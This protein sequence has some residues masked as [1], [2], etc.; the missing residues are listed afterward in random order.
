V[1]ISVHCYVGVQQQDAT[2][3]NRWVEQDLVQV[4][5]KL[6][7]SASLVDSK[8]RY[9]KRRNENTTNTVNVPTQSTAP[10]RL[11]CSLHAQHSKYFRLC[12]S[13]VSIG[14]LLY[15]ILKSYQT[16]FPN[17]RTQQRT[18]LLKLTGL[19]SVYY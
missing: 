10:R 19:H 6:R 14:Y 11:N 17:K 1:N 18:S 3:K 16:Y 5:P 7:M 12:K 8:S 13:L 9:T 15:F 4:P 2:Q